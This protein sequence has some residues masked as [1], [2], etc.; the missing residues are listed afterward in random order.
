MSRLVQALPQYREQMAALAAHV[1]LASRLSRL[2]DQ[3]A[4]AELGKLEQDL[5]YGDATSK[6]VIAFLAAHQVLPPEDKARLLL[7]YAATHQE[8]LDP[9]RQAQWQKVARLTAADMAAP[10]ELGR[11]LVM[12]SL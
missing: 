6:E 1:E 9:A 7:C 12:S 4:L 11:N 10:A 5:V 3:R 2:V 8:K